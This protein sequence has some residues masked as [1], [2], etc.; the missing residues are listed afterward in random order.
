M[1]NGFV[2]FEVFFGIGF[3]AEFPAS[4][5]QGMEPRGIFHGILLFQ[6]LSQ[7]LCKGGAFPV[8][9]DGYLQI[10]ALHNGAIVEMTVGDVIDGVAENTAG[11]GGLK[12]RGVYSWDG[13]CGND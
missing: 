11:F 5:A 1:E 8:G 13:S 3:G 7:A 10:A 12:N 6:F 9:G 4:I 2:L